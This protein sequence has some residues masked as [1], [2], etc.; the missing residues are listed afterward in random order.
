ME[1]DLG[2][3]VTYDVMGHIPVFVA[4]HVS[5]IIPITIYALVF[6]HM[7]DIPKENS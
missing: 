1:E 3:E 6:S 5:Y 4:C 2:E 7:Y